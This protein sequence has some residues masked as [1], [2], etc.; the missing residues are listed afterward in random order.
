MTYLCL[1][2]VFKELALLVDHRKLQVCG[3]VV[4]KLHLKEELLSDT[5]TDRMP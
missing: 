2:D 4:V 1:W 3:G 5:C